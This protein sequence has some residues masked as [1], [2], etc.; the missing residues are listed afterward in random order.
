MQEMIQESLRFAADWLPLHDLLILISHTS[1]E[2]LPS[3]G[4]I[5]NGLLHAMSNIN[6]ENALLTCLHGNPMEYFPQL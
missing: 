3:G 5:H 4:T 2:Q 6:P 1:Q